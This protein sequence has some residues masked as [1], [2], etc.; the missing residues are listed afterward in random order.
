MYERLSKR[1]RKIFESHGFKIT[2]D[3]GTKTTEFL[4]VTLDLRNNRYK[5]YR[6]P[7]SEAVYV[8]KDSNHPDHIKQQ[9]PKMINKRLQCLSSNLSSFNSEKDIYQEALNKSKYTHRLKYEERP[10]EKKKRNRK[11]KTIYY[12]PPFCNTV[13]TKIGKLFLNLIRK[14]FIKNH[15][16][17]KI[18]NNKTIKLSYSCL[19]N[20]KNQI[21]SINRKLLKEPQENKPSLCNCRDRVKCPLNG[22]CLTKN[23]IYEAKVTTAN[24]EERL[25][26]GSTANAFKERFSGHKCSFKNKTKRKSTALSEYIWK[27]KDNNIEYEIQ[28]KILQRIR[29]PKS[30]K[31]GCITCNLERLEIARTDKRKRLNKRNELISTCPHNKLGYF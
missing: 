8:S 24:N 21:N 3:P 2:I 25:Y 11:R 12:Q 31:D 1:I 22:E 27:N 19:P 30:T 10:E 20:I 5:P 15:P 14:I 16:L 18:F 28:W 13:K 26:V 29:A 23:I 7:G 17:H 4:D 9:I 6:K